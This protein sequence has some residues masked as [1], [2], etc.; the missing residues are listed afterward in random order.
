MPISHF[1]C[2]ICGASAPEKYLAHSKSKLRL[3]WLRRHYKR[4][5]LVAFRKWNRGR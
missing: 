4:K 2:S 5:H 1:R 3:A